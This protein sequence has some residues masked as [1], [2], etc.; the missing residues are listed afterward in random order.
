MSEGLL[1][2]KT[3]IIK[4]PPKFVVKREAIL[5]GDFV[6]IQNYLIEGAG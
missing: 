5:K 2:L 4:N 1:K 6:Q 3:D